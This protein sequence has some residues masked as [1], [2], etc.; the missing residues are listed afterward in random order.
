MNAPQSFVRCT[1]PVSSVLTVA[2][3]L[4]CW[5]RLLVFMIV[6]LI[7]EQ[8]YKYDNILLAHRVFMTNVGHHMSVHLS[9]SIYSF[10]FLQ[11]PDIKMLSITGRHSFTFIIFWRGKLC[12]V[13]QL[14]LNCSY[15][16]FS[17]T[18]MNLRIWHWSSLDEQYQQRLLLITNLLWYPFAI[19]FHIL[20][21][22]RICITWPMNT[23]QLYGMFVYY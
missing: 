23:L 5:V 12:A 20:S 3:I 21:H 19:R 9:W 1:L 2:S 11:R 8:Y 4:L 13:H 22:F 14:K 15:M 16:F 10:F 17:F 18:S 7:T 6:I